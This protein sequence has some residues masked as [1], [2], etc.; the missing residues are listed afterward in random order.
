MGLDMRL[1]ANHCIPKY[2]YNES[3]DRLITP[4]YKKFTELYP[5]A[6]T[7]DE[8]FPASGIQVNWVVASWRGAWAIHDW[9]LS[10]LRFDDDEVLDGVPVEWSAIGRLYA[11]CTKL[12]L[13]KNEDVAADELPNFRGSIDDNYWQDI[14]RTG[15][16]LKWVLDNPLMGETVLE[17]QASW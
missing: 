4:A 5:M 9:F 11:L 1:I 2:D 14:K 12:Y 3:G 6:R 7:P 13:S 15:E 16:Q 8:L 17:Y 10:E